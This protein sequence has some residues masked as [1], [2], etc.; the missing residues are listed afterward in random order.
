MGLVS[1]V[2]FTQKPTKVQISSDIDHT[3]TELSTGDQLTPNLA[4]FIL[5]N[6]LSVCDAF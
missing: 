5:Y 4:A 2:L 6:T 1:L 3:A